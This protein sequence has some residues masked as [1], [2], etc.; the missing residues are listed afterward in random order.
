[1]RSDGGERAGD[2]G[3][4]QVWKVSTIGLGSLHVILG[5]EAKG[6]A[7]LGVRKTSALG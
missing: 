6:R 7:G 2:I 3:P 4:A 1:M 5:G